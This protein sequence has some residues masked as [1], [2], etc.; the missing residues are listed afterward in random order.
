M[1]F[2]WIIAIA[3]LQFSAAAT[4]QTV[5]YDMYLEGINREIL[6]LKIKT[7]KLKDN[8]VIHPAKFSAIL[9]DMNK[10]IVVR[11]DYEINALYAGKIY[12]WRKLHGAPRA[13]LVSAANIKWAVYDVD[14][15]ADGLSWENSP[16]D[17]LLGDDKVGRPID[18]A[19]ATHCRRYSTIAVSQFLDSANRQCGLVGPRWSPEFDYHFGWCVAVPTA[20]SNAETAAR[21]KAFANCV[22][23]QKVQHTHP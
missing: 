5:R 23:H 18:P 3:A 12:E 15:K 22:N 9:K 17:V 2:M 8:E 7:K 14:A 16:T 20:T 19:V 1:K 10:V 21:A 6:V 13:R 11:R 4:A